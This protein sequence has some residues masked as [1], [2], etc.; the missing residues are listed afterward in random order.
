MRK[1]SPQPHSAACRKR[2]AKV[3]EGDRRF[4]LAKKRRDA[5][6]DKNKTTMEDTDNSMK[7]KALQDLED[8]ILG[9]TN[10]EKL[11]NMYKEYVR[12]AMEET[13]DKKM[14]RVD[15]DDGMPMGL[16]W[17]QRRMLESLFAQSRR[18]GRAALRVGAWVLWTRE[19]HEEEEEEERKEEDEG[20]AEGG[21]G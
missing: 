20:E 11:E 9:E 6:D 13:P 17:V 21:G 19:E 7:R 4:E 18:T 15:G 5:F 16:R 1:M 8:Q 14:Q 3:M 12:M 10:S 2:M